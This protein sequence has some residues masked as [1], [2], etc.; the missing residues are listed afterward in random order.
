MQA[1]EA[2]NQVAALSFQD[3]FNKSADGTTIVVFGYIESHTH[4]TTVNGKKV[5]KFNVYDHTGNALYVNLW[6]DA[7]V[8]VRTYVLFDE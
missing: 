5:T 3:A 8:K 2:V 6:D 7:A 1:N 4:E